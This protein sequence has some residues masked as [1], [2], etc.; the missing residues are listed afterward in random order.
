MKYFGYIALLLIFS[1]S[2]SASVE[3]T[4]GRYV[5]TET[6]LS[7]QI[8]GGPL[9]WEREYRDRQWT[10]NKSWSSLI[11]EHDVS[12]GDVKR[13]IRGTD[14][15][16]KLD[17]AGTLFKFGPR[18]RIRKNPDG[19]WTWQDRD[20]HRTEYAANG[21]TLSM[22]TQAGT[23]MTL[24][25]N[26]DD[27]LSGVKDV[28]D[29]QVLW[30]EYDL[31]TGQLDTVRDYGNREVKYTWE[32]IGSGSKYKLTKV[33]D[34]RGYDWL[35]DYATTPAKDGY[36]S[37]IK[38]TDPEGREVQ[39]AYTGSGRVKNI[40]NALGHITSYQFD[41]IKS[42]KEFYLKVS[43]PGGRVTEKWYNREGEVKRSDVN[44]INLSTITE[45]QRKD[46]LK[47]TFGH[48]TV[49][50][51]D[52]F[53]NLLKTTYPDGSST[54]ATYDVSNSN[55]LTRTDERGTVTQYEYF[56]N[57]HLKTLTE[58]LGTDVE[59]S[60]TYTYDVYGQLK[61]LTQVGDADTETAITQYFY[62]DYGNLIKLI[63]AEGHETE[64][65]SHDSMGNALTKI[66]GR[67]K[68]WTYT[69]DAHGNLTS[70]TNPLSHTTSYDYDKV[71]NQV[72]TTFPDTHFSLHEYDELNRLVKQTDELG[73]FIT[74][75][76]DQAGNQIKQTDK[77]QRT[78]TNT[79][80]LLNRLI[81]STDAVGNVTTYHYP[82]SSGSNNSNIYR[83]YKI[84]Y[85]TFSR[86]MTFDLR[87]RATEQTTTYLSG[88]AQKSE[89]K[90][91]KFDMTG[92]KTEIIDAEQR[93]VKSEYDELNQLIKTIEPYGIET[94]FTYDN[95]GNMLTLTDGMQQ[96]HTFT[97]SKINQNLTESRPLGQ[98]EIYTYD[99]N[100][101][102]ATKTNPQGQLI[103]YTYDYANRNTQT[104]FHTDAGTLDVTVSYG[105]NN[106]GSLVSY[107]DGTSQGVMTYDSAQQ[108]LSETIQY[109]G[110]SFGH[111][112][113]YH[114]DGE[115][116]TF[117][118]I[119]GIT[120]SYFYN[121]LGLLNNVVIPNEGNITYQNFKWSRPQT[122]SYPGG[123]QRTNTYDGLQRLK[124]FT[125][126]KPDNTPIMTYE[127][128]YTPAGNISHKSTEHGAYQ[129]GYD[130]LNR[131]TNADYPVLTDE[132]FT[133]DALGNRK[134]DS[135]TGVTEWLYNQNNQLL[136]SVSSQY[137]YDANG[138]QTIEKD[139]QGQI[140]RQ[141]IYNT[142]NRLGE[143]KDGSNQTIASY[144][145]DP[146][147]RR[148]SKTVTNPD[149]STT[150]TYFHYSDEGYSAEITDGEIISYVFH[151]QR[152][153]S[154]NPILKKQNNTYYYYQ[155]DHLDTPQI[156]H[157]NQGEVVNAKEMKAF[158]GWQTTVSIIDDEMGFPGHYLDNTTLYFYNL[159]RNYSSN[160]GRYI[161]S[162]PLKIEGGFNMYVYAFLNPNV[163]FDPL[164]LSTLGITACDGKDNL[165]I[166]NDDYECTRNCTQ[167]HEE[168]HLKWLKK[169]IATGNRAD[170]KGVP[171]RSMP[172]FHSYDLADYYI[173][174][175]E[176]ECKA[177]RVSA[178]CLRKLLDDCECKERAK[179]QLKVVEERLKQCK[180]V[181]Y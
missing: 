39:I 49:K 96:T 95:R 124:S 141:Y 126:K 23:S 117:T 133:Y 132:S 102:I 62:D 53:R 134:T 42:R 85:P 50:E 9:V 38:K 29:N 109:D 24:M 104:E 150:K 13:I 100:G 37:L 142:Q 74:Y 60:T 43:Y 176:N 80:D 78:T 125:V 118:G 98:T 63:N 51:Y 64:Y 128:T 107:N 65:T 82:D 17:S 166:F 93:S 40:T 136:N 11:F 48:T 151:P 91:F 44:G 158:G 86:Q 76:Y 33:T 108:K 168:V 59:R 32:A 84:E 140:I 113:S 111:S 139:P 159:N 12:S 18:M 89:T 72:K 22:H 5:E 66:D 35:Y 2:A 122:V 131:L 114:P 77:A 25:Y 34:A 87:G 112:Y 27:K 129:Y 103:E 81:T 69:Y 167:K 7:I 179:S 14:S 116:S 4:S 90:K 173:E 94:T 31:V 16:T 106:R 21:K 162:D 156:I 127:Y 135:N 105:Y 92:N 157:N 130:E 178:D 149:Q 164:G 154:T 172:N 75:E 54:S 120:Y 137:E 67:D 1:I 119:D 99:A 153:W 181:G 79:Y 15:Y 148:L 26:G 177:D 88:G 101:N 70:S 68:E 57:G 20:G 58:A 6:D 36:V 170:C 71:G 115:K 110:Q 8:I 61:T 41:Y 146:F 143:I 46:I 161:Q 10:F 155:N 121:E 45:D 55:V 165:K 97:Y 73:H 174:K 3:P 47:N 28:H 19:T 144:Y 171:E 123:S 175:Q 163:N 145:Y 147:G 52:E 160:T 169:F 152:T 180:K 30:I 138:N 56:P 83:A